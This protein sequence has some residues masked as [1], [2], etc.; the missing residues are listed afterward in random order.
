MQR[1]GEIPRTIRDA[2]PSND[3]LPEDPTER[4][5]AVADALSGALGGHCWFWAT[6]VRG[7]E[8]VVVNAFDAE[9]AESY[10]PTEWNGVAI[11]IEEGSPP[12][13][14]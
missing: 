2:L 1:C 4:N 6:G 9:M 14:D 13:P 12:D 7:S 11:E 8:T 3:E 5:F 10:V